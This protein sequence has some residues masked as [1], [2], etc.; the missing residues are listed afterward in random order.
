V[1][2]NPVP[3]V[4]VAPPSA[5]GRNMEALAESARA[6]HPDGVILV[7]PHG[8][9]Q[10]Q[11]DEEAARQAAFDEREC[12]AKVADCVFRAGGMPAA[13]EI[14]D[15]IRGRGRLFV[16]ADSAGSSAGDG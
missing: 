10:A 12:C 16:E 5:S 2:V 4:L 8:W 9:S 15:A 7:V 14:R 3:L 13:L 6:A 1:R 11:I